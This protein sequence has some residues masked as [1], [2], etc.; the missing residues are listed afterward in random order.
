MLLKLPSIRQYV[1]VI[2]LVMSTTFG[3]FFLREVLTLANF[4]LIYLLVVLLIA[5]RAGTRPSLLAAVLCFLS[6]NF[7][8]IK[9]Y[10]TFLVSDSRELL[11][12]IVFLLVAFLVGQL[13]SNARQQAKNARQRADE[14]EV[15]HKLASMFNQLSTREGIYDALQNVL[16]EELHTRHVHIL[17]Y[18]SVVMLTDQTVCYLVLGQGEHVYGT[19]C[20]AFD[21]PPDETKLSLL[22]TSAIQARM[23]LERIE[24]TEKLSRSQTIEEADRLKTALLHAVS[25]DLRTPITIIKTSASS[26][27]SLRQQLDVEQQNEMLAV[28]ESEADELNRMV[29]NLLDMSR[30]QA[31]ALY[32][33][34]ELNSLEEV[35]GDVA[36]RMY[37]L[38]KAE[39]LSISFPDD[40]PLVKFD[41]GLILQ[42]VTNLVENALRYEPA[43]SKIEIVT[44]L[45]TAN[46]EARIA[47]INHGPTIVSEVR[48]HLFEPFY[49]GVE[50]NIGLGLAITK[51]IIEAH[52]GRITVEDTP[53]GG[54][55]FTFTLS[56]SKESAE[57]TL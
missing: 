18:A 22:N 32:L 1:I 49:H 53:G 55:T 39:R 30:L 26:L 35:I 9:P 2:T 12:L 11:D 42:A 34:L 29:G 10:Y 23:A 50:G 36:A 3:L 24:L 57:I 5:A 28:I 43:E 20:V 6:F 21:E 56:L 16:S 37:Q 40:M 15:L 31:G 33:H 45:A 13:A 4:S 25:H 27:M 54:A 38:H 46:N 47:V 41:Y 19:L 8:L 17:P 14:K 51:G 44:T 7:F 48:Q 52:Q